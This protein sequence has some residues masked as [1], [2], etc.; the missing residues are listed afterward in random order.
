M[1]KLTSEKK[2]IEKRGR[3]LVIWE[4]PEF[5]ITGPP[6][7][8]KLLSRFYHQ[9]QNMKY[10]MN[11]ASRLPN[12]ASCSQHHINRSL[13][14]VNCSLNRVNW[15]LNRV[16]CSLNQVRTRFAIRFVCGVEAFGVSIVH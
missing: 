5:P 10:Q 16:N 11:N 15:S 7:R 6:E 3:V 4:Y 12:R 2:M 13:N 14:H 8:W 1:E 9:T